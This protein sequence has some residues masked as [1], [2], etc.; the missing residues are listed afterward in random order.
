MKNYIIIFIGAVIISLSSVDL[1]AQVNA[2]PINGGYRFKPE[3]K[4]LPNTRPTPTNL[5]SNNL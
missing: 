2:I 1:L 4:F 3:T 5:T